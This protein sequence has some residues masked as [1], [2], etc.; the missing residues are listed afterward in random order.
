MLRSK[1]VKLA[2]DLQHRDISYIDGWLTDLKSDIASLST[3]PTGE[4]N[5]VEM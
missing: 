5:I 1:A 4:A 2:I 3:P